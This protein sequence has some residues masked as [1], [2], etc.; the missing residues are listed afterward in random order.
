[1]ASPGRRQGFFGGGWPM[2]CSR[3]RVDAEPAGRLVESNGPDPL[4]A[5]HG[6]RTRSLL[7]L[8][9]GAGD[10]QITTDRSIP[11]LSL[12]VPCFMPQICPRPLWVMS[13]LSAVP[14][15]AQ[16]TRNQP[17]GSNLGDSNGKPSRAVP[18][19]VGTS[20]EQAVSI[21]PRLDPCG[22][23]GWWRQTSSCYPF[24]Q[25]TPS[26]SRSR[27]NGS[28]GRTRIGPSTYS[29]PLPDPPAQS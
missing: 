23:A 15:D 29:G 7:L 6:M 9:V 28:G 20:R 1:M 22:P 16:P 13:H 26:P 25:P 18:A 14:R 24:S 27:S 3:P 2:P 10:R 8:S 12:A 11:L 19:S 4:H 17:T 21:R 5:I